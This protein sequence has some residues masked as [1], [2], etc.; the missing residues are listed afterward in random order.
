MQEYDEDLVEREERLAREEAAKIGGEPGF[1]SADPANQAIDE[2][3]G[4]ESEGWEQTEEDLIRHATHSDD[5][6]DTIILE[7]AGRA[8]AES[9]RSTAD[10]GEADQSQGGG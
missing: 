9:D 3:G 6:S 5:R 2:A 8:E 4:G 7:G 10:Y 1:R